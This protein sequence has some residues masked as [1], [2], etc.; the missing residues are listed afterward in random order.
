MFKRRSVMLLCGVVAMSLAASATPAQEGPGESFSLSLDQALRIALKNNLDLVSAR[1]APELA[2][3]DIEVQRSNF[4]GGFQATLNHNESE[5]VPQQASDATSTDTSSLN[6][7]FQKNLRM[8]AD[9]TVGFGVVRSDVSAI[10]IVLPATYRSGLTF[11][12]NLPILKGF[13]TET[14][15]EQLVLAENVYDIS[16]TDLEGQAEVIL[17]TVEGAYW[18]VIAG[19]EAL[20]VARES[21]DRAKDL[22]ELNRKKVEVGTLAPIEITQAEAGVASEEEGVIVAVENLANAEDELRRLLAIPDSD[23]RWAMSVA[24]TDRPDLTRRTVDLDAA[25]ETALVERPEMLSAQQ[26]VRNAELSER[27]ARRETRHQLDL[28]ANYGPSGTSVVGVNESIS[29]ALQRFEFTWSTQLLYRIPIG[30]RAAKAGFAQARLSREQSEVDLQNQEQTIRVEVRRAARAVDSGFKR[31]EAAQ[32][33]V[34]L[35]RKKLEAEQ[36][37]F[38]NG[39]STTFQVREFQNDLSES[40]LSTIRAGL[41]YAKALAALEASKGTLLES[42]GLELSE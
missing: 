28:N 23:P 6:T 40:E 22:L 16:L 30:N 41:N 42:R 33:N 12:F 24:P 3:Q 26:T 8:G 36:K 35:Q 34:V 14:N 21:L 5:R 31:F 9:Y 4:N 39:M 7:G 13:G 19:A 20:R 10:N 11:D 17:Q 25:I 32:S 18:D 38:E 27:V 2:E 37:K 15:T 1:F 29:R